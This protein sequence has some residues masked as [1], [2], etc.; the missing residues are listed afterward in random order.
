MKPEIH[1][2]NLNINSGWLTRRYEILIDKKVSPEEIWEYAYN[3][4]TWTASNPDENL[5]L[6]FYNRQNRPE[7]GVAFYQK[8]TVS[9]V[10]ADLRGHILYAQKPRVCVW[11]GLA[12]YRFFGILP[13]SVP[14][15]GVI[16]I[17][18]G[19]DGY[20]LSH[21]VYLRMPNTI[22]GKLFF[23]L[24]EVFSSKKGFIPHTYKELE[25]FKANLEK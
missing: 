15:N 20:I 22:I 23:K 18:K 1:P 21:T 12:E 2:D 5:G 8:E 7:T 24:S 19:E 25:F 10:Y 11:T 17:E 4:E 3:P 14:E 9:G 13:L 6:V 16:Q